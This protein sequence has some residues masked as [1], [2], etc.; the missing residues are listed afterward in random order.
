M[1]FIAGR[2]LGFTRELIAPLLIYLLAPIT[3]FKGVL[4]AKLDASLLS[5]PFLYIA[6][7]SL[8][9]GISWLI[10]K[11]IFKSPARNILA[12]T[13]G[14]SNSGYFGFPA[15]I[16]ILG[17][18]SFPRA[19]MISFGF[20]IYESTLGFYIS[21]RGHHTVRES[22][23]KLLR[24]PAIYVFVLG[25]IFNFLNIK[26]D[27]PAFEFF[28]WVKGSFS[29]LGM[30]IIGIALAQI[31]KFKID[32]RFTGFAFFMKFLVWPVVTG[33]VIWI[34][35]QLGLNFLTPDIQQSMW[36]VSVLPM[37]ANTVA[38]AS[39]LKAEP[40][41]CAVAVLLSTLLGLLLLPLFAQWIL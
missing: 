40:E 39:L 21:A 6:I 10:S 30:M 26:L 8:I 28:S 38:F 24:L 41:K 33:A 12:Y 14:N 31:E 3:V 19:V 20:V 18:D 37:A 16:A 1:G 11:Y 29:V 7:C 2:F 17:H 34:D 4:E 32:W 5:L 9:C 15:A 36:L 23:G 27:G 22:L 35:T 25:L 13:A